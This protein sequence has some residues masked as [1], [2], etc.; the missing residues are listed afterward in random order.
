LN[1]GK[2]NLAHRLDATLFPTPVTLSLMGAL[3]YPLDR[4]SV[5]D[6][7]SYKENILGAVRMADGW[8]QERVRT[9]SGVELVSSMPTGGFAGMSAPTI[10]R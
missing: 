10:K 4:L 2:F 1:V 3:V 7:E 9:K 5:P 6:A 8:Y